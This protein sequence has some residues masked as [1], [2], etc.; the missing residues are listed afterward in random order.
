MYILLYITVF[1]CN[2]YYYLVIALLHQLLQQLLYEYKNILLQND[3]FIL[4]N[5]LHYILFLN[6]CY[7]Q[8]ADKSF[9]LLI[10]VNDF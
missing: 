7:Y 5:W 10:N 3:K 8:S 2:L 1:D 9:I 4:V 6:L